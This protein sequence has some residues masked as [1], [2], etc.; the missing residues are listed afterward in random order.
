MVCVSCPGRGRIKLLRLLSSLFL[1]RG[2]EFEK[3][4]E[5]AKTWKKDDDG[6]VISD[7]PRITV[8]DSGMGPQGGYITRITNDAR[9]EEMDEK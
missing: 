5:Y 6:G 4:S 1:F 9:E 3:N 2:D 7:Q 8:G